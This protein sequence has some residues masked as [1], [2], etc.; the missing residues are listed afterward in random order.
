[1]STVGQV[2]ELALH[3]ALSITNGNQT[4]AAGLLGVTKQAVQQFVKGLNDKAG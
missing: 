3:G 2:S 1:M 4:Q